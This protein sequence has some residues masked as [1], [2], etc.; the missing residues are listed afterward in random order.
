MKLPRV[1]RPNKPSRTIVNG[2]YGLTCTKTNPLNQQDTLTYDA[3]GNLASETFTDTTPAR[4]FGYD[5]DGHP[6]SLISST[7][8]TASRTYDAN[9]RLATAS[10]S[11]RE[12][13]PGITT[14]GYYG[15]GL[16]ASLSLSVPVLSFSQSNLFTYSYRPDGERSSLVSALGSAS[17]TGAGTFAWS[18]TNAG[19]ELS[20]TDPLTGSNPTSKYPLVTKTFTYDGYGRVSGLTL[21]R[22]ANP[23]SGYTYDLDDGDLA[24]SISGVNCCWY[25]PSTR[26]EIPGSNAIDG[27]YANGAVCTTIAGTSGGQCTFDARSGEMLAQQQPYGSGYIA[28]HTYGYDAAGRETSDT[29]ICG[30]TAEGTATRSYDTDNHITGQAIPQMFDP[31]F[32]CGSTSNQTA[33]S[34]TWGADGHLANFT[35]TQYVSGVAY[36]TTYSAHWDGN[37]VLY[38]AFNGIV[39]IYIE[40]LGYTTKQTNGAWYPAVY[41]RD[42]TGTTVNLHLAETGTTAGFTFL[43]AD[44]VHT[45]LGQC[46]GG[47]MGSE[48]TCSQSQ[49]PP[50]PSVGGPSDQNIAS[51]SAPPLDAKREDGYFD[52]TIAIQG[53]RAYDPNMNQW[54]AP[55]AYSGDVHD[56]MSQHPYMWNDN[57]PVQYL[58][59]SGYAVCSIAAPED[60]ASGILGALSKFS[61]GLGLVADAAAKVSPVAN[62]ITIALTPVAL[63]NDSE[64]ADEKET[65]STDESELEGHGVDAHEVKQDALGK[66]AEIE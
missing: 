57:N 35:N 58:D 26:N 51:I 24:Y 55:D 5:P 36:P 1:P 65:R 47:G 30:S 45:F 21:P 56:P 62:A 9:G 44:N 29:E 4:S 38:V 52:G 23:F 6:T 42:Q 14:Y 37:D 46:K 40:K 22:G 50:N 20:Q 34:Y 25:S 41:D 48:G 66:K 7:L 19:R 32:S 53:V 11:S 13:D 2:E 10:D 54:T 12:L 15:D 16:R 33:L 59:P 28:T 61:S 43:T 63:A 64:H 3:D 18:Y 8:G 60:C 49:L 17:G 39:Y 27:Q 31:G